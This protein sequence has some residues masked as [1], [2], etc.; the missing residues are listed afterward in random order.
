MELTIIQTNTNQEF[1]DNYDKLI[2]S[3]G[4]TPR[5]LNLAGENATNV[6]TGTTLKQQLNYVRV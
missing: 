6:F 5:R 4:A 3:V 1:I 2:I